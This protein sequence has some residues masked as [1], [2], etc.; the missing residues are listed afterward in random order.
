MALINSGAKNNF[1]H[2]AVVG[3]RRLNIEPGTQFGV[4]IGDETRCKGRGICRRVQLRLKEMTIVD[5]FLA[6]V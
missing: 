2:E 1:I 6:V 3:E 4:T 5:D